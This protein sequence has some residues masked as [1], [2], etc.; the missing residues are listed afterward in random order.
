MLMLR[1]TGLSLLCVMFTLVFAASSVVTLPLEAAVRTKSSAKKVS[2]KKKKKRSSRSS[3][4]SP[5]A[6]AVGKKQ[7]IDLVSSQSPELC[8]L[9]GMEY[10]AGSEDLADISAIMAA[11]G[12]ILGEASS[13]RELQYQQGED[14]A[15]LERED[16]VTV[17]IDAF[18]SLWLSYVDQE[19]GTMTEGGIP[20]QKVIDVV[21]D[22]LGTRYQYGGMTRGGIDC[23]AFTRMIFESTSK[24]ALPRSAAQQSTVGKTVSKRSELQLGDLVFF[25]TRRRVAVGHVGIYLGDDLFA[26]SSS[27]YGVTISSLKS[28]YYGKRLIG[29]RRLTEAD[30]A[31]LTAETV[32]H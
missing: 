29:A 17:D 3:K 11:D 18:T 31:Q 25:N 19:G 14:L 4:C 1:Q 32:R 8:R 5:A 28:T 9:T 21:M 22:W 23:S 20:K 13:V 2:S 16:D 12:E 15:E 6:R 27:R 10:K 7:A 24:V 30:M 26:H